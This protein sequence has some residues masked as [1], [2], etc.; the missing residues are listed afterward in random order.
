VGGIKVDFKEAQKT[1][2]GALTGILLDS[3]ESKH[4]VDKKT[5]DSDALWLKSRFQAGGIMDL[6]DE[7]NLA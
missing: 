1:G 3:T 7:P 6:V 4:G 5:I 2:I